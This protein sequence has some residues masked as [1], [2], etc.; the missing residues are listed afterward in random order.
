M[1]APVTEYAYDNTT[2]LLTIRTDALNDTTYGY[3]GDSLRISSINHPNSTGWSLTPVQTIG[4][5]S[6]TGNSL[7]SPADAEGQYTDERGKVWKFLTDR[8]GNLTYFEDPLG[9]VTAYE[10][11]L[12]GNVIQLTEADPR[13]SASLHES[14]DQVRV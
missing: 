12:Y 2:S 4:L 1:S 5:A 10:R 6:G 8:F 7:S 3:D 11:D 14:R 13:S 9:N